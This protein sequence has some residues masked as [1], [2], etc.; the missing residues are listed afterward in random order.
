MKHTAV[1]FDL[2]GTLVDNCRNSYSEEL[3]QAGVLAELAD[4]RE[5]EFL[6]IWRS[7]EFYK[8]RTLGIVREPAECIRYVCEKIGAAPSAAAVAKAVQ[9]RE[10]HCRRELIPRGDAVDTLKHLRSRDL[11]LGL[12]SVCAY[13]T[14]RLWPDTPF[15]PLFDAAVFSCEVGMVKPDPRLYALAC[16]RLGVRAERCLF[17]GDGAGNELTGAK[18]A[19]MDAVLIC[20]PHEEDLVMERE[21]PKS[22]NG[23]RI[24][25]LAELLKLTAA[26]I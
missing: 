18:A 24:S 1:I 7:D 17:I 13:D 21:D 25:A 20:A 14:P 19:G 4:G 2:F 22:W 15:A 26:E 11:K 9:M 3:L 12:L 8:M 16:E 23:P 6:A 5:D 10:D